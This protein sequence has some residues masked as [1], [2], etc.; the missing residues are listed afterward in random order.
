MGHHIG[1]DDAGGHG[2]DPDAG[3]AKLFGQG[4]GQGQN[5]AFGGGI[6]RLAGG[7][8]LAPHAGHVDDGAPAPLQEQGHG[9]IGA[10]VSASHIHRKD[11]VPNGLGRL[12]EKA[13]VT[14]SGVVDEHVQLFQPGKGR[15]H[16]GLIGNI[17]AD[18][19]RTGLCGHGLGSGV[20]FFV[21][22]G[23]PISP[24]GKGPDSCRANPPG[25]TGNQNRRHIWF[26][27]YEGP[28][29][30]RS[31]QGGSPGTLRVTSSLAQ[32]LM[33]RNLTRPPLQQVQLCFM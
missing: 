26:L 28:A 12:G 30:V 15:R 8:H 32:C 22:K 13:V 7:A 20:M 16:G 1:E 18:G 3:R 23:H 29:A 19:G 17:G 27:P 11:P 4:F 9:G 21:E 31:G 6:G 5:G 2:V 33:G 24:G 14:D 10:E 25:T